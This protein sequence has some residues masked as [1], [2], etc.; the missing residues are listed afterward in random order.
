MPMRLLLRHNR[1][2]DY[3]RGNYEWATNLVDAGNF[4]SIEKAL[5]LI[6]RDH[7]Q[8]MSLV[9]KHADGGGRVFNLEEQRLSS[10]Q[11]LQI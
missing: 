5:E 1:T 6:T 4:E 7:L 9:I 10:T 11:E 3:Y 8:G 2:G